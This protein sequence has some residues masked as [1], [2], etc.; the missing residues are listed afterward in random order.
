MQYQVIPK[1]PKLY[2]A[3]STHKLQ[4]CSVW[5]NLCPTRDLKKSL[6]ECSSRLQTVTALASNQMAAV[7]CLRNKWPELLSAKRLYGLFYQEG[8]TLLFTRCY[9]YFSQNSKKARGREEYIVA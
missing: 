3:T 6:Q 7:V 8:S 9:T 4:K 5:K 2:M 1:H